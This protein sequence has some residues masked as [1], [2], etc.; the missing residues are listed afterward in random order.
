LKRELQDIIDWHSSLPAAIL[1]FAWQ[2]EGDE[3]AKDFLVVSCGIF[4]S[5]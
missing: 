3:A 2:E 4:V 5:H 1:G